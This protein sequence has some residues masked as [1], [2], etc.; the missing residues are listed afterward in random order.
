MSAAH[1]P[2]QSTREIIAGGVGRA[3]E[4]ARAFVMTIFHS[5]YPSQDGAWLAEG[6]LQLYRKSTRF[7]ALG[8]PVAGYLIAEA[9]SDWVPRSTRLTWCI[10]LTVTA[11][12]T[13]LVGLRIE[14]NGSA[15]LASIRFRASCYVGLTVIFLTVWCSMSVF[16]W[17]A[18]VVVDHM[19]L[20]LIL[21]CSLAGSIAI[22]SAHPAIAATVF[23]MHA[24]FIIG[25]LAASRLPLDATLGRLSAI[26]VLLLAG[27]FYALNVA[28]G[29]M[30]QLEHERE[31]LV[32]GLKLATQEADRDRA[33]AVSAGRTKSQ[34]LSNMNHELRTPMNAILGF[35]EL[36]KNKSFGAAIDKY[37]EYAGIIHESGQH[38]LGLIDDM[39]DLA[40]IESGKL[41]LR[42]GEINIAQLIGDAVQTSED[43]ARASQISLSKSLGPGLPRVWADERA[44]RQIFVNLLSNALKFTPSGGCVVAF[45]R[46]E[47][48]GRIAF[49]VE[50]TG[51]GIAADE[52]P[53]VFE[54]F[55]RSRHD[56][57][58]VDRGTG[59]G[60][61][62]VKGFVEAHDGE[63]KLES[64]LG[65]G[66]RVT[67]YLPI[68]RTRFDHLRDAG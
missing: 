50:D 60:L 36:I 52:Q 47:R 61:A 21:A 41:G 37:A 56:I 2:Q 44:L 35:S 27:Q 38:L 5:V 40:K 39:L 65:A 6:Q 54:R 67:V 31:G 32:E 17:S 29:K 4:I 12:A 19:F 57:T 51:I 25:P 59:L 24:T 22:S 43:T 66:T 11:I 8:L 13:Y 10:C 15:S 20:V 42:E 18:D 45:A 23:V 9:C 48:S 26:Y 68:E 55:G 16:L 33:R 63:V 1:N 7:S 34:F 46:A 14:R 53:N 62:I 64:T 49:G 28:T 3:V 58:T 30:L